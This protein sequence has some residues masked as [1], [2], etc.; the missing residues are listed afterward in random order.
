MIS[1]A[2]PTGGLFFPLRSVAAV[3]YF[4]KDEGT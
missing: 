4:P 3:I 1:K 2:A